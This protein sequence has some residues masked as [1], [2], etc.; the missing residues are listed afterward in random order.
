MLAP[1]VS[2]T[3]AAALVDW[4][5]VG[6]A[7]RPV[8]IVAKP[9]ALALLVGVALVLDPID[10]TARTWVV[11]GLVLS[12]LGD[13]F[14]LGD[15]DA[16][17]LGGLGS[18]LGGHIA[19]VVAFVVLGPAVQWAVAGLAVVAL[20]SATLG[21]RIVAAVSATNRS[22]LVPVLAYMAVISAM[23]L[24]A[25]GTTLW[26]AAAGSL[27]FY[28]SDAAIAWTRFVQDHRHGRV[29]VIVTYHVGQA[30]IVASL[31]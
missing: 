7:R 2:I 10:S 28:A 27:A 22:M 31:V 21:R 15:S 26:Q 8:E 16:S 1:L 18:F 17:F 3:I 29:F 24:T 20:A 13:V 14:L 11:V 19:Y 6:T 12:L 9:L 4:W 5:A 25:F 30:L 23:V